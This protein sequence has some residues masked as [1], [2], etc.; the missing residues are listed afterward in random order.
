MNMTLGS[1]CSIPIEV[2]LKILTLQLWDNFFRASIN[3]E[4][5]SKSALS[6]FHCHIR[7][8]ML[9]CHHRSTGTVSSSA[10]F[11][12]PNQIQGSL[13]NYKDR[14][15]IIGGR[16]LA[17]SFPHWKVRWVMASI[18]PWHASI[19]A[20]SRQLDFALNLAQI[21]FRPGSCHIGRILYPRGVH[22]RFGS[23]GDLSR[24]Y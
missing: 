7:F 4:S 21:F 2:F 13:K 19:E 11:S 20:Q 5:V 16:R 1:P 12:L 10:A 14:G 8:A 3:G 18:V 24:R 23:K 15:P 22:D 6:S 17:R 9:S